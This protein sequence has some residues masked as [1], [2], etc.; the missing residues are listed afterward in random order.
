M[1]NLC[2]SPK[3]KGS[4]KGG[5]T[6]NALLQKCIRR[7]INNFKNLG[8]AFLDMRKDFNNVSHP[9]I[10]V[11]CERLGIPRHIDKYHRTFN[12]VSSTMLVQVDRLLERIT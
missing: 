4:G 10:S 9:T 8:V 7:V 12:T 5:K 6:F 2:I 1:E 11:A 3:Q